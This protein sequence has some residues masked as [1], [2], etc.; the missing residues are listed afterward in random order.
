MLPI[1]P[2]DAT[3][4]SPVLLETNYGVAL[5]SHIMSY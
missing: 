2:C 4:Q 3:D 1:V 5:S